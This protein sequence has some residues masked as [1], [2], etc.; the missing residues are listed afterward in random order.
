MADCC[1][2]FQSLLEYINCPDAIIALA[3]CG[4]GPGPSCPD[5]RSLMQRR[6]LSRCPVS[7]EPNLSQQSRQ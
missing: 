7:L 3:V 5:R 4:A 6:Q 2:L 1:E